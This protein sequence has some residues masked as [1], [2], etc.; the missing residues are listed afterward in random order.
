MGWASTE[1]KHSLS[2]V[3]LWCRRDRTFWATEEQHSREPA[4]KT[5]SDLDGTF[6]HPAWV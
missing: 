3:T 5:T 6:V 1:M 2:I 4:V